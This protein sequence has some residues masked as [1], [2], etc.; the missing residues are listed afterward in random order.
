MPFSFAWNE[1]VPADTDL[2]NTLGDVIRK[3]K[4]E[5]R[6]R[7]DVEHFFPLTDTAATGY[8][9]Q[10]SGKAFYQSTTPANNPTAPGSF[11]VHSVTKALKCDDGA[12][13]Q[14]AGSGMPSGAIIIWSGTIASIPSGFM[15]CDGSAGTPDLRSK[16]VRGAP[17]ATDPGATGGSDTH[18]HTMGPMTGASTVVTVDVTVPTVNVATAAHN[19]Q[20]FAASVDSRPAYFEIAFI[21]KS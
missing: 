10:G 9:R 1:A 8:H 20:D 17:P 18:T 13:W 12:V 4:T 5:V 11:W 6:E 3:F 15:L 14:D 7:V 19:H 16:F 21:M 2:A